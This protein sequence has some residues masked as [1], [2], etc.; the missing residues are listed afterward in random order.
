M[1]GSELQVCPWSSEGRLHP[2]PAPCTPVPVCFLG[3][4]M[5]SWALPVQTSDRCRLDPSGC[6]ILCRKEG[7]KVQW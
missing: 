6:G 5:G 3:R 4:R 7:W 1:L 2:L